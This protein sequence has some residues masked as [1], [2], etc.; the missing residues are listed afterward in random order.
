MQIT[1]TTHMMA[2]ASARKGVGAGDSTQARAN[3]PATGY[4][5]TAAIPSR[6]SQL[7][8]HCENARHAR[9]GWP[10]WTADDT[11]PALTSVRASAKPVSEKPRSRGSIPSA[12]NAAIANSSP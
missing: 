6:D 5:A 1:V 11:S 2:V 4:V 10:R 7:V 3:I 8:R 9:S 12:A